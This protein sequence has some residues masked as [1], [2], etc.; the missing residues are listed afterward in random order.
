MTSR[1]TA[2]VTGAANGIGKA[3][4]Y[5][6]A[7]QG[8]NLS[9]VDK[10]EQKLNEVKEKIQQDFD[11]MCLAISGDLSSEEFLQD[12]IIKTEQ[13]FHQIHALV[14][15]AAW[16][17]LE[18]MRSITLGNW[19]DTLKVCLTAPAFLAKHV[20]AS[21][22]KN[23]NA[24]VIVNISSMMSDRPA[25]NSPAYI[26]S[27]AALEALTRELAITYGRHGIRVVC[28]KPGYIDTDLSRDYRDGEGEDLSATLSGYLIDA[29]PLKGPGSAEDIAHAVC[30]LVSDE[31]AFITGT[32]LTIDGGFTTNMNSY[33]LKAKQFPKEY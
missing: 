9:L 27:K 1:K 2:I 5:T 14:N 4:A 32:S 28:V 33:Q 22:E 18:S 17:T 15:N 3:I 30:W 10:D 6:F 12:I 23:G 11:N 20:A 8:Y 21:M 16:R 7:R 31:A 19:D 24:G 13:Q 26:A 25:G 29:T